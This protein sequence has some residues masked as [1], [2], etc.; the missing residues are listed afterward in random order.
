[1][2]DVA[3]DGV[4][5]VRVWPTYVGLGTVNPVTGLA[6]EPDGEYARGQIDWETGLNGEPRGRSRIL[7]PAGQ[8]THLIYA[9]APQGALSV[10]KLKKLEQPLCLPAALGVDVT[11]ITN[12]TIE[13]KLLT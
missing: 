13:G 12:E 6:E 2:T 1:M 3:A 7:T 11:D 8:Y 10:V 5:G 9:Q 4:L